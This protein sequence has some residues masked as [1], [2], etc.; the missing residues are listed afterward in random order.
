MEGVMR[1]RSLMKVKVTA[2]GR[3]RSPLRCQRCWAVLTGFCNGPTKQQIAK[4]CK[5][6]HHATG[7]STSKD[8]GLVCQVRVPVV[9]AIFDLQACA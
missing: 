2:I 7:H 1:I 4:T 8:W 5:E 9:M 6:P 3:A